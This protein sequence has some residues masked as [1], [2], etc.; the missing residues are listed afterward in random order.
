VLYVKRQES[1]AGLPSDA[2]LSNRFSERGFLVLPEELTQI[3]LKL[4]LSTVLQG[5]PVM[6]CQVSS[7][8]L[9]FQQGID[10]L[11]PQ[12]LW[13]LILIVPE[14]RVYM[15]MLITIYISIC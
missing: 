10:L 13:L 1:G 5:R 12:R 2:V 3:S 4:L 7:L 15:S 11:I 14:Q 9:L 8:E 6:S